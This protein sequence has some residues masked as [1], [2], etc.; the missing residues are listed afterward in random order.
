V[1]NAP[2]KRLRVVDWPEMR[3]VKT[4][5]LSELRQAVREAGARGFCGSQMQVYLDLTTLGTVHD[6]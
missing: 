2:L 1:V 5:F 4:P 6:L 3:A